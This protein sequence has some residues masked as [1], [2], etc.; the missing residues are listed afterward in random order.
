MEAG[1]LPLELRHRPRQIPQGHIGADDVLRQP[2]RGDVPLDQAAQPKARGR[3]V[4]LR[5]LGILLER[6][7][8][9]QPIGA[10]QQVVPAVEEVID[11]ARRDLQVAADLAHSG[12][13]RAVPREGRDGRFSQPP[14]PFLG[15][16]PRLTGRLKGGMSGCDAARHGGVTK[17][18]LT[19]RVFSIEWRR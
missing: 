13:L 3:A 12:P 4:E 2:G 7:L 18:F 6:P 1:E 15:L 5:D 16:Q 14:P 10:H 17:A 9:Q 19:E 11:Q 8:G